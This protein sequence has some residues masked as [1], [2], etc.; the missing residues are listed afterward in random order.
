M[1]TSPKGGYQHIPSPWGPKSDYISQDIQTRQS[2]SQWNHATSWICPVNRIRL[3][4]S[5]GMKTIPSQ[6]LPRNKTKPSQHL[7]GYQKFLAHLHYYPRPPLCQSAKINLHLMGCYL[8]GGLMLSRGKGLWIESRN[9]IG[10]ASNDTGMMS[11]WWYSDRM[12]RN[13]L[14]VLE[15]QEWVRNDR[16]TMEWH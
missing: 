4:A 5:Q 2:L 16:M 14:M 8:G 9:G 7:P 13:D 10:M 3:Y 12:K 1:I 15:W 6:H 11:E